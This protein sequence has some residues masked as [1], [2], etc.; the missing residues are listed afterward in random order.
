MLLLL[1]DQVI[2]MNI[3]LKG[4]DGKDEKGTHEQE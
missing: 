1:G 4:K 3:F 2:R